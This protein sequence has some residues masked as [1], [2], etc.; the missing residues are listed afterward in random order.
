MASVHEKY[1]RLQEILR[2]MESVL[3]A[4][5]GGVDSTL[6]LKAASLPACTGPTVVSTS[7]NS[8]LAVCPSSCFSASG[9]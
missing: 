9:S 5:S 1:A 7:L 2:E 8:S 6:L 4:F 3:V